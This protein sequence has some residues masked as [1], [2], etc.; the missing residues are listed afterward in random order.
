MGLNA[1]LALLHTHLLRTPLEHVKFNREGR[2][3]PV[4]E[5]TMERPIAPAKAAE[6]SILV[7]PR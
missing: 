1:C 3:E 6:R 7:L 2:S 5:I 4:G